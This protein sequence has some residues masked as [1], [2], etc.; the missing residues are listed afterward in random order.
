[1]FSADDKRL[2]ESPS[3]PSPAGGL[4]AEHQQLLAKWVREFE[5]G[6]S[7]GALTRAAAELP[8]AGPA[9]RLALGRMVKIDLRLSWQAGRKRALEDYLREFPEL[10]TPQNVAIDLIQA[11]MQ[12]RRQAGEPVSCADL[13]ARLPR[14]IEVLQ[15]AMMQVCEKTSA[16]PPAP[17]APGTDNQTVAPDYPPPKPAPSPEA[18]GPSTVHGES[19]SGIG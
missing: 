7:D 9:R 17:P 1:M 11:E 2:V 12:A 4:D 3:P 8:A 13:S 19:L 15:R 18:Q 5:Q 16:G 10:G 6:W 14:Q